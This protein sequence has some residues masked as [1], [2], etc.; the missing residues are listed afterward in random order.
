MKDIENLLNIG[1][2]RVIIGTKAVQDSNFVKEAVKN[3]G[4]EKIVVGV[5]AKNGMVAIEGW[6]ATFKSTQFSYSAFPII[7][8]CTLISYKFSKSFIQDTP[9][10]AKRQQSVLEKRN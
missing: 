7:A 1:V 3:F 4:S 9:P 5:D 10:E 6:I 8:P 2:S